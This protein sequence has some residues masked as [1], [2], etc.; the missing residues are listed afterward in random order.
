MLLV[1]VGSAVACLVMSAGTGW[2]GDA[3]APERT[4]RIAALSGTVSTHGAGQTQ[5]MAA[6]SQRVLKPGDGLWTQPGAEARLELG[7]GAVAL[8]EQ[9][10]VELVGL[11]G[12]DAELRLIQGIVELTVPALGSGE[13]CQIDTP[14]GALRVMQPGRFVVDAGA[15]E[16]PTRVIALEG[17]AQI[18]GSESGLIVSAGQT[19][20][21]TG[22]DGGL[23]YAVQSAGMPPAETAAVPPAPKPEAALAAAPAVAAAPPEAK[24][25]P[26]SALIAPP[27]ELAP[28]AKPAGEPQ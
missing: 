14:R 9:T 4:A 15:G 10:Q 17:T 19:G 27:P 20:L 11:S 7:G 25:A 16:Q 26:D 8:K 24:P 13:S 21:V 12:S 23:S 28:V 6:V 18:V 22:V 2:A 3:A 1:R 5:W